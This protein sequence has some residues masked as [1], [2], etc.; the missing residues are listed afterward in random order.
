MHMH[1]GTANSRRNARQV[2]LFFRVSYYFYDN[3]ELEGLLFQP[4]LPVIHAAGSD[5]FSTYRNLLCMLLW[6]CP[7][8]LVAYNWP[9]TIWILKSSIKVDPFQDASATVC[10]FLVRGCNAAKAL[11][12]WAHWND[13]NQGTCKRWN[14]QQ[15]VETKIRDVTAHHCCPNWCIVCNKRQT[16]AQDTPRSCATCCRIDLPHP[17]QIRTHCKHTLIAL[18]RIIFKNCP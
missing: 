8:K 7:P 16:V 18:V 15:L 6:M 17:S 5:R 9:C 13:S 10:F 4:V 2:A 1:L 11:Q 14:C 3:A 12:C